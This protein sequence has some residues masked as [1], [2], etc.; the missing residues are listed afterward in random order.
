MDNYLQYV[1][2]GSKTTFVD[3]GVNV[4]QTLIKVK[5]GGESIRYV[6]FEANVTCAAYVAKLIEANDFRDCIVIP[7]ALSSQHGYATLMMSAA[8]DPSASILDGYRPES[9]YTG[10]RRRVPLLTGDDYLSWFPPEGRLVVKIDVEGAELDV[11]RGFLRTIE[12]FQPEIVC[13]I[14]PIYDRA[15]AMRM[16]QNLEIWRL[17]AS[18][19]Y[20]IFR[21]HPQGEAEP[22][23]EVQVHSDLSWT[24]YAFVPAERVDAFRSYFRLSDGPP[25]GE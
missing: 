8:D 22:T 7:C 5:C 10:P 1:L 19:N 3:V 6:G 9:F 11:I 25:Q 20:A 21:L 24:N 23:P 12:K 16:E 2:N 17:F 4:G 13:E 14:L 18:M 15:N